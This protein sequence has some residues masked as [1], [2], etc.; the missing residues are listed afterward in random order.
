MIRS[1]G[2]CSSDPAAPQPGAQ[3]VAARVPEEGGQPDDP[4]RQHD[5]RRPL[6]G[7]RAGD[8]DDRLAGSDQPDER[9]RLEECEHADDQIG[10]GAERVGDVLEHLL[11]VDV[12]QRPLDQ[13]VGDEDQRRRRR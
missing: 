8:H 6:A 10:P 9:A 13:L 3:E 5:R 7:D 12:G 4:D 2:P 11:R 1:F